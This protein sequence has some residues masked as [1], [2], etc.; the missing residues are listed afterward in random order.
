MYNVFEYAKFDT[1]M[2]ACREVK[3]I[4]SKNERLRKVLKQLEKCDIF[5]NI[6]EIII[7]L[8]E[9]LMKL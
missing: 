7:I 3:Y 5:E 4:F 8:G 2:M 1:G 6:K 9:V